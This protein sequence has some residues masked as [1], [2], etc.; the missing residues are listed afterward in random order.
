MACC[1]LTPY[2]VS[3]CINSLVCWAGT[4]SVLEHLTNA[5]RGLLQARTVVVMNSKT[6]VVPSL[7]EHPS[8]R[9]L[10]KKPFSA[11]VLM[12]LTRAVRRVLQSHTIVVTFGRILH[13]QRTIWADAV[14]RRLSKRIHSFKH[15]FIN[16]KV[17]NKVP[18]VSKSSCS[19]MLFVIQENI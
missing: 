19:R 13:K 14:K 2:R 3:S 4:A 5:V 10:G 11:S 9:L 1:R 17:G 7:F 6:R 12:P 8:F 18:K 16:K 15:H